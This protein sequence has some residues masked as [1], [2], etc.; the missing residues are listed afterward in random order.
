MSSPDGAGG[1][2]VSSELLVEQLQ[3]ELR[4]TQSRLASALEELHKLRTTSSQNLE[5]L[6]K[7][8][9]SQSL[10]LLLQQQREQ[11]WWRLSWDGFTRGFTL[12]YGVRAGL[13]LATK[14]FSVIRKGRFAALNWSL[15]SETSLVYRVDAVR[16]GLF[17]GGYTA[18]Y[19]A[20]RHWLGKLARLDQSQRDILAGALAGLCVLFQ[21]RDRRRTLALYTLARVAQCSY[22]SLKS[23]GKWHFWGSD[24]PH[25]DWLLFGTSTAQIMWAY[26]MRPET[27][28]TSYWNFIV[29]A[30]PIH[31]TVLKAVKASNE[32][33]AL[34]APALVEYCVKAG[35]SCAP[36]IGSD[37]ACVP[38]DI[39]HPH[40]AS[41]ALATITAG[42][43]TF[44]KTFP[45]YMS[46][47]LVPYC[48]FN[49]KRAMGDPAN[50]MWTAFLGAVR[51]T[52]FLAS[53]VSSFQAVVCTERN[54]FTQKSDSGLLYMLAGFVASL[55]L[56]VEKKSRRSE[57]ALY[58]MPRALD[59]LFLTLTQD[60]WVPSIHLGEVALFSACMGALMHYHN[61]EPDTMAPLV[62]TI[63]ARIV[64]GQPAG[65]PPTGGAHL[66]LLRPDGSEV[67]ALPPPKTPTATAAILAV[68]DKAVPS[69][70]ATSSDSSQ[71]SHPQKQW[72]IL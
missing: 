17:C 57:L 58:V 34:D 52:A 8:Q 27:L 29:N 65:A 59:S 28:P 25:G 35:A 55:S 33:S 14:L 3:S 9:S 19:H 50:T 23:Q 72:T 39:M 12:G 15:L 16:L 36:N 53:F 62:R 43:G 54:L 48:V 69:P 49:A 68:D 1:R 40:T 2:E 60:K 64:F 45:L 37:A 13:S 47:S 10:Q 67:A 4:K 51:S 71:D 46:I 7:V 5:L 31:K 21:S 30:G 70:D 20:A 26:V 6:A 42:A 44:R 63:I 61:Q 18:V 32:G 41:C 66:P 24:W 56:L 11:P 38:C 22:N